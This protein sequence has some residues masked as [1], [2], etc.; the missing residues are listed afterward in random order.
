MINQ[1]RQLVLMNIR[2]VY[3]QPGVMFWIFIFPILMA[4]VLG[5]AFGQKDGIRSMVGLVK[6]NSNSPSLSILEKNI[7]GFKFYWANEKETIRNMK[8]GK[9]GLYFTD[10]NKQTAPY[11]ITAHFDP[12]NS[13]A[14]FDY[15]KIKNQ[16][17]SEQVKLL[18]IQP[19]EQLSGLSIN[20]K[21]VSSIG[22]RY[23][24]FL[25]PGLIALGIMNSCLW[26]IGWSLIQLRMKKFL[27]RMIATPMSKLVFLFSHFLVRLFVTFW[28]FLVL[29]VFAWYFFDVELSGSFWAVL[30]IIISGNIAFTGIA[31]L[32]SA[33]VENTQAGNGVMNAITL[34]MMVLSG[35]FFSYHNFPDWAIDIIKILPLTLLADSL[36]EVFIQSAGVVDVIPAFLILG[37]IG[38]TTTLVGVKIYKWS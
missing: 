12:N 6:T 20:K 22:N 11:K 18:D 5:V 36:R 25:I 3:R 29:F 32:F 31:V 2:E 15:H 38:L 16:I 4:W 35:I 7:H 17:L 9:I 13:S 23:I 34:P 19:K 30:L 24:D 8:T 26:G 27:R 28:E 33:K 10:G 21:L 1:L 14:Y 37:L